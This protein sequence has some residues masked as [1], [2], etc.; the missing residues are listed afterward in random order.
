MRLATALSRFWHR[1]AHLTEGRA[2]LEGT[3]ASGQKV[4]HSALGAKAF[5]AAA[6]L[7]RAQGDYGAARALIEKSIGLWQALQAPDRSGLSLSRIQLGNLL[8]DEGDAAKARD[9]L[10]ECVGF[11]R[12]RGDPWTLAWSLISLGLA[13]RDQLD[14]AL[15]RV[16]IEEAVALWRKQGDLWGLGESLHHLGLVAYRQ[17]DY[18]TAHALVEEAF[19][20]RRQLT[21]KQGIAYSLHTLGVITLAQG[22]LERA[23]PLLD[24]GLTLFRE[25]G[26]RSGTALSLQYQGLFAHLQGDDVR[27][28]SILEEGLSLASQTGPRWVNSNYLLWLA[29]ISSGHHR[30]ER[31][32]RLAS[33]AKAQLD[34][35]SSFWDAFESRFYHEI[36]AR[37]RDSLGEQ[38]LERARDRGQAM[39]P[40]Q[41]IEYALEHA[42]S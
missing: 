41:A 15:A 3:L 5:Y 8:R 37:A 25:V 21:D 38:A 14:Y 30:P 17:G 34:A 1:R 33:A 36:I 32:V 6:C 39:T 18:E 20:C 10:E 4:E 9:L 7:A 11:F 2:W 31:A 26:D 42:A 23:K 40:E 19:S 16:Q 27:A 13:S 29:G 12:G 28:Q 24:Q 35:G 22:D